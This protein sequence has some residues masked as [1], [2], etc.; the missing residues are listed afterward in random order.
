MPKKTTH[1]SASPNPAT[2]LSFRLKPHT[3]TETKLVLEN[4][5]GDHV[6]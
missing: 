4:I 1:F 6:A 5:S 2:G 3:A